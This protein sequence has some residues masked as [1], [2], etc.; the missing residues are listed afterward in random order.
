MLVV[1]LVLHGQSYTKTLSPPR[2]P[3]HAKTMTT[4]RKTRQNGPAILNTPRSRLGAVNG[5]KSTEHIIASRNPPSFGA[6]SF[7]PCLPLLQAFTSFYRGNKSAEALSSRPFQLGGH[8][9]FFLSQQRL[10]VLFCCGFFLLFFACVCL[11]PL[12]TFVESTVFYRL[13]PSL[14]GFLLPARLHAPVSAFDGP[15]RGRYDIS[16]PIQ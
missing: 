7:L 2:F 5:Q 14:S 16:W 4:G 6:Q 10:P 3:L 1:P 12:T 13:F 11:A 8:F 15:R 9:C